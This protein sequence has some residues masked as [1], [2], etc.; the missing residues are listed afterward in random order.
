MKI[1]IFDPWWFIDETSKTGNSLLEEKVKMFIDEGGF[2]GLFTA[3]LMYFNCW[4]NAT[5]DEG[6]ADVWSNNK[7]DSDV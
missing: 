6:W 5:A 1:N 3:K 4:P 2:S 7:W